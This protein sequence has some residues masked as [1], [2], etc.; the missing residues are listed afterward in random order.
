VVV[1]GSQEGCCLAFYAS[2]QRGL[3]HWYL[4]YP[5]AFCFGEQLR[6]YDSTLRVCALVA[7]AIAFGVGFGDRPGVF[8]TRRVRRVAKS[9][10]LVPL[11]LGIS[12]CACEASLDLE[13]FGLVPDASGAGGSAGSGGDGFAGAGGGVSGVSGAGGGVS[14]AGVRARQA[15]VVATVWVARVHPTVPSVWLSAVPI[16]SRHAEMQSNAVVVGTVASAA[17]ARRV[18]ASR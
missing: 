3:P 10:F 18:S 14:G 8:A 17:N 16:A 13:R 7:F 15:P 2:W 5:I 9:A 1:R 11:G 6:E 4:E 12:I